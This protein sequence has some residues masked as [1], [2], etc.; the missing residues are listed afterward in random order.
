MCFP[1]WNLFT[2]RTLAVVLSFTAACW[3]PAAA[4][5]EVTT[6]T[7]GAAVVS[8]NPESLP[9]ESNGSMTPRTADSIHDDLAARCLVLDNGSEKIALVVCDS[10]M[11]PR[12]IFD[13]A[14]K[15]ASEKTRIPTHNMLCS[16]T[17]THTGVSVAAVF[18]SKVE[19]KYSELLIQRIAE[20]I[21]Q[22]DARR[23]PAKIG[24]AVGQAPQHVF[25][26]RWFMRPGV[27]NADPFQHGTDSV[28]MN[29]PPNHRDLLRPA[30]PTDPQVSVLAVQST[31]GR[32]IAIWANY[33]LHYVGGVPG[34][35]LSA[36]YYGEFAR[37]FERLLSQ[38]SQN[39]DASKPP[40]VV[41]MTNGT[42]GNINNVNFFSGSQQ[43]QPFE[44]IRLVASD[45]AQ[46]ALVAYQRVVYQDWIPLA[47]QEEELE[48]GV[49][50]PNETEIAQAKKL[51]DESVGPP[52]TTLP[53]I[54]A[55]ETLELAQFPDRLK[56]KLQAMRLGDLGIAAIPCETFAETGLELKSKSP[57]QPVFTIELA[58]GY[59]G[60]LP[61]PE[62]HALGGYETWRAKS[63]YLEVDAEPQIVQTLLRMLKEVSSNESAGPL[64]PGADDVGK[65]TSPPLDALSAI[66]STRGGRHWVDQPTAP[67]KSPAESLKCFQIEP[68]FQIELVAA[69]PL[70]LDPVWIT[71]DEF[72]RM[73]VAEYADYPTGP[74][75]DQAPPLSR[76]VMLED[77]D[78]DG[79]MD[80]R[81]VFADHLNFAHSLVA[82]RDGFLVG[83]KDAIVYLKDTN[84]DSQADVREVL[85]S[86]FRSPHPQMQIGCPQ[87]GI[88]NWIYFNYGPGEVSRPSGELLE[89]LFG[90]LPL[91]N[92]NGRD[93]E[94]V[95]SLPNKD[96]RFHCRTFEFGSTSGFGQFGNTFDRR[97]H[98]FFCTNRNPIMT[99]PISQELLRRNPYL[100]FTEDQYD[101]APSGDQSVVFP[102]TEVKS[103]Y[104]S[105][106]GTYTSACG[107]TAYIGDRFEGRLTDSVFVCE[108]IGHLVARY[109]VQ[110]DGAQLAARRPHEGSE[111]LA[112][113]DAWFRPVSLACGPD[114]AIY[115]ADMSRLWVEHPQFLPAEVAAHMDLRAGENQGR[116]WRIRPS[117]DDSVVEKFQPPRSLEELVS[118]LSHSNGWRR[119]LAQ[120]LLVER[121]GQAVPP[122]LREVLSTGQDEFATLHSLWTLH[123]LN[124]LT[125]SDVA[126]GLQSQHDSVRES[127]LQLA[128]EYLSD[129][130]IL[131]S[132][133]ACA[134]DANA[135]V[136]LQA[137]LALGDIPSER[138]TSALA[139]L[140]AS[141]PAERW[142][143]TAILTSAA[144]RSAEILVAM[145]SM[146]SHDSSPPD[147]ETIRLV[148]KLAECTGAEGDRRQLEI[149]LRCIAK[150]DTALDW[151]KLSSMGG[152]ATGLKRYRGEMGQLS[153]PLLLEQPPSWLAEYA[154]AIQEAMRSVPGIARD[155]DSPI[156]T[157]IAAIEL[158][159]ILQAILQSNVLYECL[160]NSHPI[161]VQL[162]SIKSLRS[163]ASQDWADQILA[164]WDSL[165][166][167]VRAECLAMLL[168]DQAS[169]RRTLGA[170]VEHRMEISLITVDQRALLLSHP[171]SE[172]KQLAQK[173]FGSGISA[174]RQAVV[175]N[176][177]P[178]LD[179]KGDGQAGQVVFD[180]VCASC[181]RIDG[182]G[183]QV[184]PDLSDS[185]NRSREAILVDLIDPNQ[186]IDPQYV[187]HQILTVDGQLVQG[188]SL[189]ETP[190][191]VVLKVTNGQERMVLRSDIEEYK[192]SSKSLMPEGVEL[193]VTVQQ[194]ADL[195]EF[196][197][198]A[199][200]ISP[201]R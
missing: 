156:G 119:Q 51:L 140:A 147:S 142:I 158:V 108:P 12:D 115:L 143:H 191:A 53:A 141:D 94:H 170:M 123:G 68:G 92:D 34:N 15:L 148:R 152:L 90:S 192:I 31:D 155:P 131:E 193:D 59:N 86:G 169:A 95:L 125:A 190:H 157:R 179:L 151:W 132:V 105:H 106:A 7:A 182:R 110:P 145:H 50:K 159:G 160:D 37:Q 180:R 63:S 99:A 168:A 103:N 23:E 44:Q 64:T 161:E 76:I 66:E 164:K 173:L 137:A 89:S 146:Q 24:W 73:F 102:I 8:I 93:E 150:P 114:G 56:L 185:R 25:N 189:S 80:R 172:I 5:A 121:P 20:G 45:V 83:T 177:W 36:D 149:L 130:A 1:N 84:A 38:P 128:R 30:G 65:N 175:Q 98:R 75:D 167:K 2:S 109:T 77:L 171:D 144:G 163:D 47:V 124:A 188:L 82:F 57:L 104:L 153:L 198:P 116:I 129:E 187:A 133:L 9:V 14:K 58:N 35:A 10:C 154:I 32:P 136:R 62:Q 29:P 67:P 43:Q 196:L 26:R 87:W 72:G 6:F 107:T 16:A 28:R 78:A 199:T 17:H 183:H 39:A 178:A 61:T 165:A 4:C 201:S 33:S 186:R 100:D 97:G 197:K 91:T 194:M 200:S 19:A 74:A 195:L 120:R 127:S 113:T 27:I 18:Q 138:A 184:G 69:E 21:A 13:S 71:F 96:F 135:Q 85:F 88:D 46:A 134:H 166:P 112:S 126:Q 174:D 40:V 42:S 111:F 41:A 22:A 176:F 79:R 117:N 60:Y 49:R 101:V 55:N 122:L 70:V 54:Y 118:M 139:G 11:I 52:W 81:H 162:A 181:H 48:L 3:L